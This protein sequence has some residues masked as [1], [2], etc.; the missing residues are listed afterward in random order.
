MG[1]QALLAD[2]GSAVEVC[3]SMDA[4][5]GMATASRRRLGGTKHL[6]VQYL[7]VQNMALD[8]RIRLFKVPGELNRSDL[9]TK[10]LATARMT[11]LLNGLGYFF[12]KGNSSLALKAT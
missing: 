3:V 10:H 8:K 7:W 1:L 4:S 2:L 6:H 12:T 9:L 11:K 5:A